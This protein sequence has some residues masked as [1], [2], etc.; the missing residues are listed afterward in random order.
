MP[1]KYEITESSISVGSAIVTTQLTY[2]GDDTQ[3]ILKN[4]QRFIEDMLRHYSY[5]HVASGCSVSAGAGASVDISA[6]KIVIAGRTLVLSSTQNITVSDSGLNYIYVE[7]NNYSESSTRDPR[8]EDFTIHAS[9]SYTPSYG[10]VLLATAVLSGT[11]ITNV[12]N[13]RH[14]PDFTISNIFPSLDTPVRIYDHYGYNIS[15]FSSGTTQNFSNNYYMT[16]NL[17][18][19][20]S[21]SLKNNVDITGSISASGDISSTGDISSVNAN[22]SGNI[23]INGTCTI[24]GNSTFGGDL[25]VSNNEVVSGNLTVSG[26]TNLDNT[27]IGGTFLCSGTSTF[28]SSSS[29][30]SD[31]D[32]S[33][34]LTVNGNTSV[35]GTFSSSGDLSV[36]TNK[37]SV[38]A[39]TGNTTVSGDISV[40]GN[41]TVSGNSTIDG[42][43]SVGGNISVT[44]TVDGVD[45]SSHATNSSAHHTR[46]SLTEDLTASVIAQLQ[47]INSTSISSTQWSYLGVLDQSLTKS[48]SVQFAGVKIPSLSSLSFNSSQTIRVLVSPFEFIP[49]RSS[50]TSDQTT[51]YYT[52]G[53]YLEN[54]DSAADQ[55]FFLNIRTPIGATITSVCIYGSDSNNNVIIH[56]SSLNGSTSLYSKYGKINSAISDSIVVSGSYH[57][58]LQVT[59][60]SNDKIYGGYYE[61]QMSNLKL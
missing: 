52:N 37:F 19:S 15:S 7:L 47:N 10:K 56:Y 58:Y 16:G 39:S 29:F 18:V 45:I 42:N 53:A 22:F 51:T 34:A 3:S 54:T 31:V 5:G 35:G 25:N 38:D 33:G 30:S 61:Y 24:N 32:V 49:E 50:D 21:S 27:T 28:S 6:G 26:S 9:S 44:G 14:A 36:N 12:S 41:E 43:L 8:N 17:I 2:S 4:T 59:L 23:D 11:T 55:D 46:Y 20:G 40:S 1:N 48:S 57:Y 13:I 60:G